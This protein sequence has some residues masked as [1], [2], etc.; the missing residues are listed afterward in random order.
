MPAMLKHNILLIYRSFKRNKSTFLINLTGLSTGLACVLLIYFW[1]QDELNTDKFFEKDNQL[2]QV[3]KN[4]PSESGIITREETP[5]RLAEAL[6]T[7]MP[8]VEFA[9]SVTPSQWF[10]GKGILSHDDT[11]VK[12]EG[13]F[14]SKDF[15]NVFSYSFIQGSKESAFTDKHNIV[16]SEDLA[17][18]LFNGVDNVIGKTVEWKHER[19]SGNFMISGIF[20]QLPINSTMKTDILFSYTLFIED[21]PIK[22]DNWRNSDPYTYLLSR[23]GTDVAK[24]NK[25]IENFIKSKNENSKETIFIQRYSDKYL[26]N[27]YENG[28]PSGGRITYVTL[29]SLVGL[30]ILINACIN[31]MN[32]S[33]ARALKRFKEVGIKKVFGAKRKT[34]VFQFLTESMS[35]TLISFVVAV[36]I[37]IVFLPAFNELTGKH[38]SLNSDVKL[39]LGAFSIAILTGLLSGSYPSLYLSGFNPANL[40]KGEHHLN[41]SELLI[42]K[43]LVV[44]QFTLSV[45]LIFS[46]LVVYKQMKLV[47]TKNLGYNRDNVIY[48]EKGVSAAKDNAAYFVEL[49][50][51]LQNLKNIS[52]V[53]NASNFRHSITNR[54]GGTT[55]VQWEGKQADNKTSFTDLAV[56]YDFI[57]TLGIEMK[58]GRTFS[59]DFDQGKLP[60][61]VNE[62]AIEVMGLTN[63][64]GKIVRFGSENRV[65]IGVTRNFHFQSFYE[66]IKPLYFDLS[67]RLSNFIVKI[68]SGSEKETIDQI[69]KLYKTYNPG[70]PFEYSFLD[71]DYKSLYES[72]NRVASLSRYF[73]VIAFII[74]CLGLFGLSTFNTERR[75]KEI[76]IRRILGSRELS[77]VY[78]L[79]SD[80]T[81]I[82][83]ASILIALPI[84]YLITEHWLN[85][86]AYK[87][88]LESWY[89]IAVALIVLLISWITIVSQTLK[90]VR[91]N[92]ARNL[93]TE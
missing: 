76:G 42:R 65:I 16:I 61:I 85:S 47:Y 4:S 43:A 72:E 33:T 30:F 17:L 34:L 26:H 68:R 57:E 74:S 41:L 28:M 44:F 52:G 92:P 80:F 69:G 59:R 55:N 1:V 14:V 35:I 31:F 9:A 89:F 53:I 66:D 90:A 63:P 58:E 23:K 45:I 87:I 15:F 73:T 70:L 20:R 54:Q 19:L 24:F 10:S 82:I 86:F 27:K 46:T 64:I 67:T 32:L 11:Q 8:E 12:A 71:Q 84:S 83:F 56:G 21:N 3:M 38:L 93:Q 5:G 91:I 75:T 6:S 7:E 36:C 39:F 50:S 25:K 2:Y 81:K 62:K 51:F 77:I 18:K 49:E 48:F 37:I 22:A 88:K 60:V 78:L 13:E 79:F 40:L 29:F